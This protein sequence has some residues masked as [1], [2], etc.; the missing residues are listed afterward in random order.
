V[1]TPYTVEV[2]VT[3]DF[4]KKNMFR[5]AY[6]MTET[7][8]DVCNRLTN[9]LKALLNFKHVLLVCVMSAF[10]CVGRTVTVKQ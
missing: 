6:K 8:V 1:V 9:Y 3:N 10:A 5:K 7:F 4:L 2:I